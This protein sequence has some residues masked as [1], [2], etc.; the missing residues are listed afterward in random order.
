LRSI[1]YA[2]DTAKFR[3]VVPVLS[4]VR[5]TPRPETRQLLN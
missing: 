5:H 2:K 3:G 4:A 1:I